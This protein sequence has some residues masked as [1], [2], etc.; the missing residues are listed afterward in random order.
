MLKK[1]GLTTLALAGMLAFAAPRKAEARPHIGVYFGTPA[2]TYPYAYGY[3]Y[4]YDYG[5]PGPA[6]VSPYYGNYGWGWGGHDRDDWGR[7]FHRELRG[8][9]EFHEHGEHHGGRR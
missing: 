4:Y 3:P 6:Y 8:G 5:Y 2:Y 9:H 7:G 1:I